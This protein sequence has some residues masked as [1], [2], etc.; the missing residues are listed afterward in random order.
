MNN[1]NLLLLLGSFYYNKKTK[2][3][4][5]VHILTV[6][7]IYIL[8]KLFGS[9]AFHVVGFYYI[10]FSFY[11]LKLVSTNENKYNKNYYCSIYQVKQKFY[12]FTKMMKI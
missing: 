4:N 9:R 2:S 7:F 12:H 8:R 11:C 5:R 3:I 10:I 1:V 6:G